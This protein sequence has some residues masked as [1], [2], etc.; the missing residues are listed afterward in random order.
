MNSRMNRDYAL[1]YCHGKLDSD[2]D[3]LYEAKDWL[4]SETG[5]TDDEVND[6]YYNELGLKGE[7]WLP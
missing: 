1:G 5:W 6:F 4:M 7:R 3:F 2:D